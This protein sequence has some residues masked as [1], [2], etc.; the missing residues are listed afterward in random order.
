MATFADVARQARVQ[1]GDAL[2]KLGELDSK[3]ASPRYCEAAAQFGAAGTV[4]S[5]GAAVIAWKNCFDLGDGDEPPARL[6]VLRKL[7]KQK[8]LGDALDRLLAI[9]GVAGDA[10]LAPD[11][12]RL[13]ALTAP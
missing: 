6:R 7:A 10:T 5:A 2:F 13:R 11:L 8:Q 3:E 9:P 12:A 1:Y 4:E